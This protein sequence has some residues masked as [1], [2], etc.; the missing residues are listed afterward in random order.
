MY[1]VIY[2]GMFRLTNIRIATIFAT[3]IVQEILIISTIT[4]DEPLK[5]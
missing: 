1:N 3:T 2:L 4:D 5:R